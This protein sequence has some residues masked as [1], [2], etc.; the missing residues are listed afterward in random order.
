MPIA[1][2]LCP[3][4]RGA[5][6]SH[7]KPLVEAGLAWVGTVLRLALSVA[8][9]ARICE[10]GLEFAAAQVER[11]CH[12]VEV[13]ASGND[14]AHARLISRD[15]GPRLWPRSGACHPVCN[16]GRALLG[17]SQRFRS[18]PVSLIALQP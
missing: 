3:Y 8:G 9:I 7:H 6:K 4:S 12:W 15:L 10:A 1:A 17:K 18:H 5:K 2:I 11:R 13:F 14:C 16:H